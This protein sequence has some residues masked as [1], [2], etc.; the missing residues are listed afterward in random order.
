MQPSWRKHRGQSSRH[1]RDFA[2][3]LVQLRSL[4]VEL[5]REREELRRARAAR[6]CHTSRGGSLT[7]VNSVI[8]YTNF[9][10]DAT[11]SLGHQQWQ[12]ER[13]EPVSVGDFDRRRVSRSI[14]PIAPDAAVAHGAVVREVRSRYGLRG[15]RVGEASHP[16]PPTKEKD[17]SLRARDPSGQ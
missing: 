13:S 2:A 10:S 8:V 3:E 15:V 17:G 5:Q 16:G 12:W 11:Q 9:R 7:K 1:P 14:P 4:V 6:C